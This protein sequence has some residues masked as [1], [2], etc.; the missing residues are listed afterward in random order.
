MLNSLKNILFGLIILIIINCATLRNATLLNQGDK[1]RI[2]AIDATEYVKG[3]EKNILQSTKK[4]PSLTDEQLNILFESLF[5]HDNNF[6][7]GDPRPVLYKDD[8]IYVVPRI[9]KSITKV[10]PGQ[11]MLIVYKRLSDGNLVRTTLRTTILF[12]YDKN[13]YNIALGESRKILLSED[14][15]TQYKKWGD[16]DRINA[17]DIYKSI[18]LDVKKPFTHKEIE[19]RSHD[20]WV[21]LNKTGIDYLVNNHERPKILTDLDEDGSSSNFIDSSIETSKEEL[22]KAKPKAKEKELDRKELL[23]LIPDEEEL[24]LSNE[25]EKEINENQ[26]G[27]VKTENSEYK[28]DI[29]STSKIKSKNIYNDDFK[30]NFKVDGKSNTKIKNDENLE[31][32]DKKKFLIKPDKSSKNKSNTENYNN[33]DN[34]DISNSE[35]NKINTYTNNSEKNKTNTDTNNSEKNKTNKS[36]TN[37]NT[38]KSNI[39]NSNTEKN[40]LNINSKDNSLDYNNSEPTPPSP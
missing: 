19:N 29:D 25:N 40:D 21:Y 7:S 36:N 23:D 15:Y 30:F 8:L 39:N 17:K 20:F 31:S 10:K 13:G 5:F 38:E 3:V 24:K 1:I 6:F 11:S 37:N 9:K 22:I 18:S 16:I 2:Y 32:K 34:T 33:I 28:K 12:W 14:L 35:K 4:I 27:N 26:K